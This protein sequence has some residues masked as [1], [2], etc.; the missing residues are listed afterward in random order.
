[1]KTQRQANTLMRPQPSAAAA[2]SRSAAGRELRGEPPVGDAPPAAER[3]GPSGGEPPPDRGS[4]GGT[5][6]DASTAA[7]SSLTG[8]SASGS[9]GPAA[10]G[11]SCR[12]VPSAPTL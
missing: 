10:A 7:A 1:M 11:R 9:T 4:I 5:P 12:C 6:G 8:G 3:G 2:T